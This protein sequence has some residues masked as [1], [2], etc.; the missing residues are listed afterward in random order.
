MGLLINRLHAFFSNDLI[1]PDVSPSDTWLSYEGVPLK[2]HY[3]LGLL[4]DL[5]SGAEPAYPLDASSPTS[6][7]E[8]PSE[9]EERRTLPWRLT[10]HFSAFPFDQLVKLESEDTTLHDLFRNGVKEADYLRTGTGKTVMFLSKEDSTQLWDAVKKHDFPLFSSINQKLLNPQGVNLRH[11]PVR[12]YLPHAA[13]ESSMKEET[14]PG[15]LRVVQSLV[16][17]NL[18]SSKDQFSRDSSVP[19]NYCLGQPQT[20]GTALNHIL[21]SLFPSRR[22]PLLAQAVLHGAVLPLSASVEDLIRS[23]AYLDGWLHIAVVMMA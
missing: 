8:H 3:P 15:S 6:K 19:S 4:Y 20:I 13:S 17:P 9:G 10:V 21:P 23:A 22:S 11:L 7:S 14:S 18:S 1:Y 5:Y 16:T 2:W 12:L